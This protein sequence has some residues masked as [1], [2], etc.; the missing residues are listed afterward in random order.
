MY[1]KLQ[2]ASTFVET[3]TIC[4]TTDRMVN[5]F[6]VVKVQTYV[7]GAIGRMAWILTKSITV[8]LA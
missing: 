1:Q 2:Q 7:A 8:N 4:C 3:K 6:R 5:S